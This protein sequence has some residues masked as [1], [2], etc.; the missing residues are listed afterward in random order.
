MA[1]QEV[2]VFLVWQLCSRLDEASCVVA[3]Q[4]PQAITTVCRRFIDN[5][6]N[7]TRIDKAGCGHPT[8]C[9][10]TALDKRL[11]VRQS[12]GH[13]MASRCSLIE[14]GRADATVGLDDFHDDPKGE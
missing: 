3:H 14:V 13:R 4:V 1:A 8:E 6:R 12:C 9:L 11:I 7:I 2:D 5:P 10:G